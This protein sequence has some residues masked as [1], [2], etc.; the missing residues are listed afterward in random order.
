MGLL[1]RHDDSGAAGPAT[2]PAP[3]ASTRTGH[4]VPLP[5]WTL[6]IRALQLALAIVILGLVCYAQRVYRDTY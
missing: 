4:A 1:T 5:R 6:G 2:G 3:S